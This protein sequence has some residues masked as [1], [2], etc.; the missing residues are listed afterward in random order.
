MSA[1]EPCFPFHVKDVVYLGLIGL[2][3]SHFSELSHPTLYLRSTGRVHVV[4][5]QRPQRGYAAFVQ[6]HVLICSAFKQSEAVASF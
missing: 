3:G 1:N 2:K 6:T 5:S 4:L